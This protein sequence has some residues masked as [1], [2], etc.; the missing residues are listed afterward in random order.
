MSTFTVSNLLQESHLQQGDIQPVTS[1]PLRFEDSNAN[2]NQRDHHISSSVSQVSSNFGGPSLTDHYTHHDAPN[3]F[4]VTPYRNHSQ[5]T[6][7]DISFKSPRRSEEMR[8]A[9]VNR[10]RVLKR[11]SEQEA[12]YR[13]KQIVPTM[14]KG[15]PEKYTKLETLRHTSSYIKYLQEMLKKLKQ[16]KENDMVCE[17]IN[18]EETD[19]AFEEKPSEEH[20]TVI[21]N[22]KCETVPE[23]EFE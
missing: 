2:E 13:L 9:I 6:K 19:T 3:V 14:K 4:T 16:Q 7:D 23:S 17:E 20:P 12:F 8:K 15:E 11:L 22:N 1:Q 21:Q 10:S 5:Q 18:L